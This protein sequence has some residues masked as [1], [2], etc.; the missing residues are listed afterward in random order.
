MEARAEGL[1]TLGN[2][3]FFGG[4]FAEAEDYFSRSA[5]LLQGLGE[6]ERWLTVLNNRA[7]AR[8]EM[9]EDV[10][11]AYREVIEAAEDN[12]LVRSR[13]LNNVGTIFNKQGRLREAKEA[14]LSSVEAAVQIG[15]AEAQFHPWNNLGVIYHKQGNN[16]LAEEA[17]TKALN[18]ARKTNNKR[19]IGTVLSNLAELKL[20]LVA[21]QEAIDLLEGAGE[22][23]A[24]DDLKKN[25][26]FQKLLLTQDRKS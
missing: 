10:E 11:K 3:S 17:Y 5:I 16:R 1:N 25:A 4:D 15:A 6:R 13:A 26:V 7:N 9:G 23:A 21:W 20:D 14:Y 8:A 2:L 12:L 24:A 18:I 22:T 19:E